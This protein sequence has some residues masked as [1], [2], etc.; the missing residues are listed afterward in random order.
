MQASL[1][2]HLHH[3]IESEVSGTDTDGPTLML[4]AVPWVEKSFIYE[5]VVLGLLP[6]SVKLWQAIV[7][8]CKEAEF[9]DLFRLLSFI[10]KDEIL[11]VHGFLEEGWGNQG[12]GFEGSPWEFT[13]NMLTGLYGQSDNSGPLIC[14]L[15]MER[16][17]GGGS[18]RFT[19]SCPVVSNP[20]PGKRTASPVWQSASSS[21]M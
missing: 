14:C 7:V 8:A 21:L 4:F 9:L 18:S 2:A 13:V 15:L 19:D 6:A 12:W 10:S 3:P 20:A 5:P 16:S 11:T 17:Q 1:W